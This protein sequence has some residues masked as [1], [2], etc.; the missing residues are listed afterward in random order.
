MPCPCCPPR[1]GLTDNLGVTT[2][3][4]TPVSSVLTNSPPSTIQSDEEKL[5]KT[6]RDVLFTASVAELRRKAQEHSAAI[7]QSLQQIQGDVVTSPAVPE[8]PL[9]PLSE[10]AKNIEK[11]PKED[12]PLL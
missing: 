4:T 1:I 8:L 12:T 9:L 6:D 5:V 10:T 7:W 3:I 11:T 2:S